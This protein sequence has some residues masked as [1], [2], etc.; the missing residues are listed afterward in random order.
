MEPPGNIR[1]AGNCAMVEEGCRRENKGSVG[2]DERSGNVDRRKTE[3]QWRQGDLVGKAGLSA[4]RGPV[5]NREPAH[6][7]SVEKRNH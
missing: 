5:G 3:K 7:G 2:T 6:E 1:S 4:M